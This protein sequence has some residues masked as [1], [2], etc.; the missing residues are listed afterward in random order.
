MTQYRFACLAVLSLAASAREAAAQD[1]AAPANPASDAPQAAAPADAATQ[2]AAAAA[3]PPVT[4]SAPASTEVAATPPPRRA[5][6]ELGFFGGI[7][8]PS[9]SHSL[10]Q[11][12]HAW[13]PYR[14][15][16]PEI[17]AR[18]AYLPL[19]YL[20][21]ELEGSVMPATTRSGARGGFGAARA[22][23]LGQVPAG[24]VTPF[25][26]IGVDALAAS[27]NTTG[28]DTDLGWH[29][30]GG[31]KL[32]LDDFLSLRVDVRDTIAHKRHTDHD[33]AHYPEILGG[34]SFGLGPEPPKPPPPVLD[35]DHD[36]KP[37]AI[38]RCPEEPATTA[39]GCPVR[40]VDNDGVLDDVDACKFERGNPP[41]GCPIRD[42]DGDK[43]IDELDRCPDEAGPLEGCPDP[44]ADHDGILVPA[45]RCPNEPETKNNFED[46][47]GCP[48]QIPEKVRRFTGVIQGIEF[49]TGKAKIRPT[50]TPLLDAAVLVLN[51]YPALRLEITGHTD[52]VGT[53]E[54]NVELSE[55]RAE[56]VKAY[57]VSKGIDEKRIQ[58]RGAGPNEPIAD[59]KTAAGRQ[60]NRRIEF[61]LIQ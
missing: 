17:G 61:K 43:V 48:D 28:N 42:R 9:K 25:L 23:V 51:E 41:C 57:F 44:D 20:G 6:V 15:P 55:K 33:P 49:D 52:N 56:S 38:D 13:E 47:D 24:V 19:A 1:A 10:L 16:A 39:D 40:D 60:K 46:T 27:S 34:L 36:G 31:A 50:S 26:L 12:G 54:T 22:H 2:P 5:L 14:S 3:E 58:T 18:A 4:V 53:P 8:F 11:R 59:N 45:D 7:F 21:I 30:G 32:A 37:D 35:K 29:F